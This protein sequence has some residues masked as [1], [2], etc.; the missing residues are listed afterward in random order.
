[1]TAIRP[2]MRAPEVRPDIAQMRRAVER[3]LATLQEARRLRLAGQI[4]A[5]AVERCATCEEPIG[6][7]T[8][9]VVL[10]GVVHCGDCT[11]TVEDGLRGVRDPRS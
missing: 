8:G 10:R 2:I 7:H 11:M 4:L 9:R 1:M 6:P 5:S 3:A